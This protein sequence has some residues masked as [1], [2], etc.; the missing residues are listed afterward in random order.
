MNSPQLEFANEHETTN[1][2]SWAN[3]VN[4]T[5]RSASLATD[6][7]VGVLYDALRLFLA[8]QHRASSDW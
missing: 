4:T 7:I 6:P 3:K 5:T 2:W 8:W 1:Y